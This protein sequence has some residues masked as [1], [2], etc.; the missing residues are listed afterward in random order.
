MHLEQ[1]TRLKMPHLHN[2]CFTPTK[3]K[4]LMADKNCR[5]VLLASILTGQMI[6]ESLTAKWEP[7]EP[8]ENGG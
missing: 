2:Y 4:L 7:K 8:S 1:T 6:V 5:T 3:E